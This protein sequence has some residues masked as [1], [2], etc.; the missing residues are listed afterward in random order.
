MTLGKKYG[1]LGFAIL[2]MGAVRLPLEQQ[3]SAQLYRDKLLPMPLKINTGEKLG[4]TFSAVSLGGL[5]TL[6]A[7]FYNLRAFTFFS[8]QRWADVAD[9][10]ELI[11][12]LAPNTKY[13]WDAGSWHMAYNAASYYLYESE[14]PSVRRKMLWKSYI[15]SGRDFLKRGIRSNPDDPQ[16][17]E[18]LGYLLAD[19]NKVP[20]FGD[21]ADAYLA[22]YEAYMGAVETGKA[23]QFAKRAA[24]YSLARVKGREADA[25]A[26]ALE[27]KTEQQVLMPTIL[28]L[29][30]TLNYHRDPEQSVLELVDS[31]FLS[32]KVAY[33]VLGNQWLRARDHFPMHGVARAIRLLETD[34]GVD[35][36]QSIL[37]KPQTAPMSLNDFF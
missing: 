14:M 6:V 20:A 18:R 36:S 17:Y 28:G 15:Q 12:D 7:T 32:R 24:L 27:I 3:L 19:P 26:L 29:L 4:Q 30:Y 22:S 23:R 33:Q 35:E 37:K 16:L 1:V 10:Y 25:L 9:T 21:P 8:Q 2:V 31:V 5:R 34:L 11:V 13:Y